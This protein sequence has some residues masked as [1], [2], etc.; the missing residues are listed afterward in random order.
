MFQKYLFSLFL[1]LS[2]SVFADSNTKSQEYLKSNEAHLLIQS[3]KSVTCEDSQSGKKYVLN[4][5]Q[6]VFPAGG[7]YFYNVGNEPITTEKCILTK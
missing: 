6:F 1:L 3:G 4:K 2:T 5:L 7:M